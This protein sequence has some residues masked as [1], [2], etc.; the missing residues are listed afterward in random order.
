MGLTKTPQSPIR[1]IQRGIAT[2]ADPNTTVNVT[3]SAVNINKAK[4]E[5]TF[6]YS[7]LS[8]RPI[9]ARLTSSTNLE[10][11]SYTATGQTYVAWE[12]IEYV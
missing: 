8:D 9:R 6:T 5:I 12:V 11:Y 2:H 10:L 4:V 1:S 3:I 7:A